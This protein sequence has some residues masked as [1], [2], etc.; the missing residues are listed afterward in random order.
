MDYKGKTKD[1]LIALLEEQKHLSEGI[2]AKDKEISELKRQHNLDLQQKDILIGELQKISDKKSQVQESTINQRVSELRK[3][4]ELDKKDLVEKV[5][6][7]TEFGDER[8][9][10]LQELMEIHS[11]LLRT[12]QGSVDIAVSLSTYFENKVKKGE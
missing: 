1:E 5:K 10:Q 3:E 7:L 8:T 12:L 2:K 9:A 11:S 6:Y 4:V